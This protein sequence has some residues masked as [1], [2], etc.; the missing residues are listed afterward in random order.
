MGRLFSH[1]ASP[2]HGVTSKKDGKRL[3]AIPSALRCGEAS[4]KVWCAEAEGSTPNGAKRKIKNHT[5]TPDG[6]QGI[7]NMRIIQPPGSPHPLA[8]TANTCLDVDFRVSLDGGSRLNGMKP[9]VWIAEGVCLPHGNPDRPEGSPEEKRP[10]PARLLASRRG[11]RPEKQK[12][13]KIGTDLVP[14]SKSYPLWY[15]S[16]PRR[17]IYR[18]AKNVYNSAGVTNMIHSKPEK[19][20]AHVRSRGRFWAPRGLREHNRTRGR[21]T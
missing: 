17:S 3:M 1:I 5:L 11:E 15:K 12:K 9:G 13:E 4:H 2:S 18:F 10:S 20:P 8:G 16:T 19:T 21:S 7:I 14:Q 6:V